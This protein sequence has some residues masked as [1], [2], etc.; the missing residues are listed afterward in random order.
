MDR[1]VPRFKQ[2]YQQEIAAALKEEFGYDNVME[3]PKLVK[4]SINKGV[5]EA[6]QTKNDRETHRLFFF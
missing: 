2:K 3:I 4:I 1:Y 6:S 5:G